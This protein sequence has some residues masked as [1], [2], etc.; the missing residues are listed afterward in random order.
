MYDGEKISPVKKSII[1]FFLAAIAI[2][3]YALNRTQEKNY[4]FPIYYK[5]GQG[6]LETDFQKGAFVYNHKIA[7]IFTPLA[8]LPYPVAGDRQYSS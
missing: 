5:A 2:F 7:L 4:D 3:P 8:K 6:H 1:I